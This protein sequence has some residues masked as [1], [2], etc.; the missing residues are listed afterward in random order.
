M[1]A[2]PFQQ[3]LSKEFTRGEFLL[4]LGL[5]FLAVTGVSSFLRT[6]SEPNLTN[7]PPTSSRRFGVGPYGG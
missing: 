7:K 6:L 4:H 2:N 1:Y 3:L 5:L